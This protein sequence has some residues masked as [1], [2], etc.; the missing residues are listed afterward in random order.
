VKESFE[1][2]YKRQQAVVKP[3]QPAALI[4][5]LAQA[6]SKADADSDQVYESFLKGDTSVEA[7]VS[8]YVQARRLYHQRELKRQAALQT[9]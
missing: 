1:E 7:F 6:A 3:L 9:L 8:Q 4:E 5:A 2:K